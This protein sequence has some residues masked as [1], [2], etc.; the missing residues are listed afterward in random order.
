M[1]YVS[2]LREQG[3][4]EAPNRCQQKHPGEYYTC[5]EQVGHKGEHVFVRPAWTKM[6]P[7]SAVFWP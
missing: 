3:K 6:A 1:S 5:E 2:D 4:T 7:G